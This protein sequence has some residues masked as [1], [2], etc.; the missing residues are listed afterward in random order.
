MPAETANPKA[1]AWY[2]VKAFLARQGLWVPRDI[3]LWRELRASRQPIV[4]G[5]DLA[6]SDA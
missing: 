2:R 3:A 1:E 6:G 5:I 4:V